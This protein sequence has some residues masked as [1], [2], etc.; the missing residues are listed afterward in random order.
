M[1]IELFQLEPISTQETLLEPPVYVS[2]N[3]CIP[4]TTGAIFESPGYHLP[5][6]F[7]PDTLYSVSSF[8]LDITGSVVCDISLVKG[9]RFTLGKRVELIMEIVWRVDTVGKRS[10]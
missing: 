2:I 7:H 8:I 5:Y 10:L 4:T 6:P 3:I 9:S 1:V